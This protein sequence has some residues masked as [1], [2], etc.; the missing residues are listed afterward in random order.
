MRIAWNEVALALFDRGGLRAIFD[1]AR[2]VV[3]ATIIVA[4][5]I[6]T[7]KRF[8][9]TVFV[10]LLNPSLVG[11]AVAVAGVV[12]ILLNFVDGLRKLARLR[13]PRMLQ[14]ALGIAYFLVSFRI[15]QLIIWVRTQAC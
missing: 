2:N 11:Y 5:G 7:T 13:W 4:A 3:V 9:H 15:V 1:H 12:L 8:D 14:M 6:E 10:D